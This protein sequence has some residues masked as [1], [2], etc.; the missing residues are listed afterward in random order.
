MA[1]SAEYLGRLVDLLGGW[2]D[3]FDAQERAHG[4]SILGQLTRDR[5][6]DEGVFG[7]AVRYA[8]HRAAFDRLSAEIAQDL[9]GDNPED[10]DQ[11]SGH[12]L[13]GKEQS[14][15]F[16]ENKL[17]T[18]ERELLATPYARAKSGDKAQGSFLDQLDLPPEG[19]DQGG[20]NKVT[21]FKPL[22]RKGRG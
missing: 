17:L 10:G 14:R 19:G 5:L 22:R 2:P 7:M 21:P 6:I 1:G 15:A 13:S 8:T 12:Y 9:A 20:G 3:H 11:D 4:M 16:H 18:L